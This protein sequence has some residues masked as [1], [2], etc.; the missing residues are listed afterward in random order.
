MARR[1]DNALPESF[2]ATYELEQIELASWP[3]RARTRTATVHWL[4]SI[5]KTRQAAFPH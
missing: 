4:E 1:W 2:F 5:C 3:T